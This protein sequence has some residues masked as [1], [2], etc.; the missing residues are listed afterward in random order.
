MIP[1]YH[2]GYQD[3]LTD[4]PKDA[5]KNKRNPD[6]TKSEHYDDTPG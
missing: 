6:I 3:G 5:R 4:G 2:K 1:A